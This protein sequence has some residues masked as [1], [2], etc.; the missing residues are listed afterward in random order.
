MNDS[1]DTSTVMFADIAGSTALYDT[2]GDKAAKQKID[3]CLKLMI[4]MTE[5]YKGVLIKTIG[6]EIMCRYESV[7]YAVEAACAM[8]NIIETHH[9]LRTSSMA[10]RVGLHFGSIIH[11]KGDIFGDT[12]NVAARIAGFAKARQILATNVAIEQL[13][14]QLKNM[15]RAYDIAPLKGK[16]AELKIWEIVWDDEDDAT[17]IAPMSESKVVQ[18]SKLQLVF[19]QRTFSVP[20]STP[21][22]SMG[23]SPEADIYIN[24]QFVSRIHA[25]IE[26]SRSKYSLVD[27]SSNGTYV[28]FNETGKTVFLH[29]EAMPITGDGLISLGKPIETDDDALVKFYFEKA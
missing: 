18:S 19:A 29:R 25:F 5:E 22:F 9:E 13:N 20:L 21:P 4:R 12:V 27:N 3:I 8:H 16:K 1:S 28:Y 11:D 7:D 24:T 10:I 15:A 2:L 6:D 17:Y 26:Y 23:R 14:G